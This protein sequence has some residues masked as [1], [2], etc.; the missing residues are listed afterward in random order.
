MFFS[1][2]VFLFWTLCSKDFLKSDMTNVHVSKCILTHYSTSFQQHIADMHI[3]WYAFILFALW[4]T[5][6][7]SSSINRNGTSTVSHALSFSSWPVEIIRSH[8]ITINLPI[9][10]RPYSKSHT[11]LFQQ[12]TWISNQRVMYIK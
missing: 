8:F 7:E 12:S 2:L 11:S 1:L 10:F 5:S 6:V 9:K 4:R 3:K